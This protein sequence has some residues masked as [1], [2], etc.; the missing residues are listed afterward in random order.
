MDIIRND[1]N[2]VYNKLNFL[3][4]QIH[5]I[6]SVDGYDFFEP[7][8]DY[9]WSIIRCPIRYAKAIEQCINYDSILIDCS[10]MGSCSNFIKYNFKEV[11][12][13]LSMLDSHICKKM[14]ITSLAEIKDVVTEQLKY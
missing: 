11:Q 14:R 10:S 6:S 13:V 7:N 12:C 5:I 3:T 9:L 2:I 4:P 8:S 1:I